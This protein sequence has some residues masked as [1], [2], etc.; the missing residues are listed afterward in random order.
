[1]VLDDRVTAALGA[2]AFALWHMPTPMSE[3]GLGYM[4]GAAVVGALC[5]ALLGRVTRAARKRAHETQRLREIART[6]RARA[7]AKD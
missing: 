4:L 1:M 5:G 6:L 3:R 7:P 2:F